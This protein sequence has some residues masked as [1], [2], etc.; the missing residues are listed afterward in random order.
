MVIWKYQV[1]LLEKRLFLQEKITVLLT[2]VETNYGI[3]HL[4]IWAEINNWIHR[5][6]DSSRRFKGSIHLLPSAEI[7]LCDHKYINSLFATSWCYCLTLLGSK[8]LLTCVTIGLIN[9]IDIKWLAIMLPPV[10]FEWFYPFAIAI[11]ALHRT[12]MPDLRF[13]SVIFWALPAGSMLLVSFSWV[14]SKT[15]GPQSEACLNGGVRAGGDR[16]MQA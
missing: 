7:N 6:V 9:I 4:L 5:F 3:H 1:N 13:Y 8:Q 15:K 2:P 10:G 12:F 16:F 11:N 14:R